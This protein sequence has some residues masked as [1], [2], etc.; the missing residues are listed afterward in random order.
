M[1]LLFEC[2]FRMMCPECLEMDWHRVWCEHHPANQGT[3]GLWPP[4]MP[5]RGVR[6]PHQTL[7][8]PSEEV[9]QT[10]E[11]IARGSETGWS[12]LMVDDP[13]FSDLPELSSGTEGE[14]GQ[15]VLE[16]DVEGE[17]RDNT[18]EE[19]M[20]STSWNLVDEVIRHRDDFVNNDNESERMKLET[21]VPQEMCRVGPCTPAGSP[22][23]EEVKIDEM[24][25]SASNLAS[26]L[27]R[28]AENQ[29]NDTNNEPE[30]VK[31]ETVNEG[32]STSAEGWPECCKRGTCVT[33]AQESPSSPD[34][35]SHSNREWRSESSDTEEAVKPYQPE[36]SSI[37]SDMGCGQELVPKERKRLKGYWK[38]S[39]GARRIAHVR[40]QTMQDRRIAELNRRRTAVVPAFRVRVQAPVVQS[41]DVVSRVTS[42]DGDVMEE[43]LRIRFALAR[44]MALQ[45]LITM[46]MLARALGENWPETRA[47]LPSEGLVTNNEEPVLPEAG[48]APGPEVTIDLTEETTDNEESAGTPVLDERYP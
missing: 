45:T 16:I 2:D 26:A 48:N 17:K 23:K 13:L 12:D 18:H 9:V 34:K 20:S 7:A 6:A 32:A 22:V 43:S 1:T 25:V 37:S 33:P 10:P 8:T 4:A 39:A 11:L 36:V 41:A 3:R 21:Y 14:N 42:P 19:T 47:I 38:K 29:N 28:Y 24:W 5:V 35:D 30:K 15:N 46:D 31:Q 40:P 27:A 44:D